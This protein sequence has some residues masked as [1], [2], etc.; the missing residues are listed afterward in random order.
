MTISIP[1]W[2]QWV[3]YIAGAD[4]WP[5]GD[6]D[7]LYDLGKIWEAG[8]QDVLDLVDDLA[9]ARTAAMSALEGE[10]AK[11][12]DQQFQKIF[13]GE[14]SAEKIAAVMKSLGET[15]RSTGRDVEHTKLIIIGMLAIAAAQIIALLWSLWGSALVA[16]VVTVFRQGIMRAIVQLIEQIAA[17]LAALAAKNTLKKLVVGKVAFKAAAGAAGKG[18]AGTVGKYAAGGA[19]LGGGMEFGIQAYQNGFG[20]RD[21]YDLKEIGL[22]AGTGLVGGAVMG[23]AGAPLRNALGKGVGGLATKLGATP[24]TA[25]NVGTRMVGGYSAAALGNTAGALSP[26]AAAS[27]GVP[28][29]WMPEGASQLHLSAASIFGGA[30]M[31]VMDVGP[32]V[33]GADGS[34]ASTPDGAGTGSSS[35]HAA[36][37]QVTALSDGASHSAK[38]FDAKIDVSGNG[39]T[40]SHTA[41]DVTNQP[42]A[43]LSN[44]GVQQ[45]APPSGHAPPATQQ[46]GATPTAPSQAAPASP[47]S[48][49]SSTVP[50]PQQHSAGI[51]QHPSASG[52]ET[53]IQAPARQPG[54]PA[55]RAMDGAVTPEGPR[56]GERATGSETPGERVVAKGD[57]DPA[58]TEQRIQAREQGDGVSTGRRDSDVVA[59]DAVVVRNRD[60][61]NTSEAVR[62][63]ESTIHPDSEAKATISPDET[64]VPRGGDPARA[65]DP[66]QPLGS[67]HPVDHTPTG[68]LEAAASASKGADIATSQL[69]QHRTE[70]SNGDVNEVRAHAEEVRRTW[71]EMDETTQQHIVEQATEPGTR[72]GLG[73]IDGLPA[74]VRDAV[75]RHSLVEDMVVLYPAHG[76]MI[77]EWAR[78]VDEY[79]GDPGNFRPPRM[80]DFE[81]RYGKSFPDTTAPTGRLAALADVFRSKFDRNVERTWEQAYRV[82]EE[83]RTRQLYAY[84][85]H[86][87]GGDGRLLMSVG[88]LDSADS[89]MVRTPGV[90]STMRS[91]ES[92]I[93]AAENHQIRASL[94]AADLETAVLVNLGYDAPAGLRLPFEA[95][96]A[97]LASLGGDQLAHD[98]AGLHTVRD[99]GASIH[100]W[101][102]SYGSVVTAFAGADAR[103][104]PFVD[105]VQLVGSP[106][107]GPMSRAGDFG[108]G[109][110]VYVA[111]ASG[112]PITRFGSMT[113]GPGQILGKF[114]LGIDPASEA[115]GAKRFA[116]EYESAN[117]KGGLLG[118]KS[119]LNYSATEHIGVDGRPTLLR[120]DPHVQVTE[121]LDNTTH[122]LTGN[123]HLLKLESAWRAPD[124]VMSRVLQ[125]DDPAST[126]PATPATGY[127]GAHEFARRTIEGFNERH[128]ENPV[129]QLP[130]SDAGMDSFVKAWNNEFRATDLDHVLTEVS[131]GK[132]AILTVMYGAAALP[133]GHPGWRSFEIEP[134]PAHPSTP[135]VY[136][137][138]TPVGWPPRHEYPVSRMEMATFD[139]DG[140]PTHPTDHGGPPEDGGSHPVARSGDPGGG[141]PSP[142]DAVMPV[143]DRHGV[144]LE[145]LVGWNELAATVGRDHLGEH[146]TPRQLQVM[147]E[148]RMA[149]PHPDVGTPMQK[150]LDSN[151]VSPILKQIENPG[152]EYQGG[153]RYNANDTGGCM[154]TKADAAGLR[155][156]AELL[157]GLRLD[158]GKTSPFNEFTT[159]DHAYVVE[160]RLA[161][162]EVRVP[163]GRI[164]EQL[165]IDHPMVRD[166]ATGDPPHTGTGY[167][168]A[169]KGLNPEYE[170]RNGKWEPGATLYRIDADGSRHPVARL[171]DGD[172]WVSVKDPADRV[173]EG[174]PKHEGT[175]RVFRTPDEVQPDSG[176]GTHRQIG[177]ENETAAGTGPPPAIEGPAAVR[178]FGES[179]SETNA[180]ASFF[181]HADAILRGTDQMVPRA[182]GEFTVDVHGNRDAVIL[183]DGA[184]NE[185]HL[186]PREFADVIRTH[187]NWDG[188]TPIRLL[189][190]DTGAGAHPF[191]RD[192]ARELGVEVTAPDRAVWAY[193]DGRE[194]VV[195]SVDRGPGPQYELRPRIPPDGTWSRFLPDGRVEPVLSRGVHDGGASAPRSHPENLGGDD[196]AVQPHGRE[197]ADLDAPAL[198]DLPDYTPGTLSNAETRAVYAH[199]ELRMQELN[200]RWAAEGMPAEERAHRMFETRNELRQWARTLMADREAAA[201]LSAN[202]KMMTWDRLV[203]KTEAK[204]FTGDE[205]FQEIIESSTRSRPGV[206]DALGIDPHNPPPLPPHHGA[207]AEGRHPGS[208]DQTPTPRGGEDSPAETSQRRIDR[209]RELVNEFRENQGK[210]ADFDSADAV[211][212][213]PHEAQDGLPPASDREPLF[214]GSDLSPAERQALRDV[215]EGLSPDERRF[216]YSV[217]PM[218]GEHAE[219]PVAVSDHYARQ[220]A[221]D[222]RDSLISDIEMR[223]NI[224]GDPMITHH[225]LAQ[226]QFLDNLLESV[227]QHEGQPPRFL[228][229]FEHDGRSIT[230]VGNPDTA[231]RMVVFAPGTFT[232]HHSLNPSLERPGLK[233]WFGFK[234]RFEKPGYMEVS[235]RIHEQLSDEFG[236][237]SVAVVDYQNYHA[238]QSLANPVTG[239][240]NARFA[241]EG[242]A[243][244]RN[245]TDRLQHTNQVGDR[246]LWV[247]G[248]SYGTVLV[249]EAAKGGHG[250][251]ADGIINLGSPGLRVDDVSG[252][253][254]KGEHLRPGDAPVHTMTRSDDPIR[255]VDKARELHLDRLGI[256][257]GLMPHHPEFGGRVWDVDGGP[258]RDPHNAYFDRDSVALHNIADIVA[259]GEPPPR[260]P[261][262]EH[263]GEPGSSHH[264][265]G[266][267]GDD[268]IGHHDVPRDQ[269][270]RCAHDANDILTT[271]TGKHA[272][273]ATEPS[274]AGVPARD[275]FEARESTA[276]F[277]SYEQVRSELLRSGDGA[278]A[279]LVSKWAG[280]GE[281]GGHAYV[282]RNDNGTVH[283]YE[284]IGDRI[285][286]SGWPPRWG[287]PAVDKT[288]VGYFDRHGNPVETLSGHLEQL[289]AADEIGDVA[290]QR[291]LESDGPANP[292]TITDKTSG[293]SVT[294]ARSE[295]VAA[296]PQGSHPV[297]PGHSVTEIHRTVG[298]SE[299]TFI[300]TEG[301]TAQVHAVLRDVYENVDRPYTEN[302][303]TRALSRLGFHG[304]HIVG[305]RFL[306]DQGEVNLFRQSE[307]FNDPVYKKMENEWATWIKKGGHVEVTIDLD[308]PGIDPHNVV[309]KYDV[310]DKHGAQVYYDRVNFENNEH[311]SFRR[312]STREIVHRLDMAERLH[313][314]TLAPL[315]D[316]VRAGHP[317][318]VGAEWFRGKDHPEGIDPQYGNPLTKHWSYTDSPTEAAR[319]NPDVAA[320]I[321]D[322]SAPYGRDPDGN[323]YTQAA[324]E[325]RFNSEGPGGMHWMNFPGNDGAVVGS[326]VLYT[327]AQAFIDSY[328]PY[329]DRIG[330]DSGKYLGVMVDGHPASWEQRAMHV[331]S[332]KD[333]YSTFALQ[334]LP[335]GWK[336][337]ISEIAPGC[338]QP[339]GGLQ[340][341]IIDHNGVVRPVAGLLDEGVLD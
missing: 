204:G 341:R 212:P 34:A 247:A 240:P 306:L 172:T 64:P 235:R 315:P 136:D 145:Q 88:N 301:K 109:V 138:D 302:K 72:T 217:E 46:G 84:D 304:G 269:D 321:D 30:T 256:G 319:M 206:N 118:M 154:S 193:P 54:L 17:R 33:H 288:A 124:D 50:A 271:L 117:L 21:G 245:H 287:E 179:A 71:A 114:G 326:R 28:S 27:L 156:P 161:E 148:A 188:H 260:L 207:E 13:G 265:S 225:E 242:A 263:G 158:Y 184:G 15:A 94:R 181:D 176:T 134:D 112:D 16:A 113:P 87:H 182:P 233:N 132:S 323:A 1:G 327:D 152:S 262:N 192:L 116:A 68:D 91:I 331:D 273:L 200:K 259:G 137:G 85:P 26:W 81:A 75:N 52:R 160:G 337:E 5:Q 44:Q 246:Q 55:A 278:T 197:G 226:L 141:Q 332:L 334:S 167:T 155:T 35:V 49:Q 272:E 208:E 236:S 56:A 220:A 338:G 234:E 310:F 292:A 61:D 48:G 25:V 209:I 129:R 258:H 153:G 201:H 180:G 168:G 65:Q 78:A 105:T 264:D 96:T 144:T 170:V 120:D 89:I 308:S 18:L 241:H 82:P 320:L 19:A 60:V 90:T 37:D 227:K 8:A 198:L 270:G 123:P 186:S 322:P 164:A 40:G 63:S 284:Q 275:L 100:L 293:H 106:G 140:R 163:I 45:Q 98:V 175:E 283:L 108:A 202:E 127:P 211:R 213:T 66:T 243:E 248:H 224:N 219:L 185:Y 59:D 9:G 295:Q 244:L 147:F 7:A 143:L 318:D 150:V 57:V 289:R 115:F 43:D 194:P 47:Q 10:A 110:D 3:A 291:R 305:F 139:P 329:L 103:V 313:Q 249:G 266:R 282:A 51:T 38:D 203:E 229:G 286:R 279:L 31:G 12:F 92:N 274:S 199:G 104:A 216:L 62:G 70:A 238:P 317:H 174:W 24:G 165:G 125:R 93:N 102:H 231:T 254:L 67:E 36:S 73:S 261:Q 142:I 223:R 309:V 111:A 162:G 166:L 135:R 303:L 340:V 335:A 325:A 196:S 83:G 285:V 42:R 311:Q 281:V 312:L 255:I 314:G 101:G 187:T 268:V 126:H 177:G 77:R 146:F 58:L 195:S 328:G 23:A 252:L 276:N 32:G 336:I 159:T 107:A 86:A 228:L 74:W 29:S 232:S 221:H 41:V 324:Y 6:E 205:I 133:D 290:G 171:E 299:A 298:S 173:V 222:L 280:D 99:G 210:P 297:F 316:P 257:H 333:S 191:A 80:S 14:A 151:S 277:S 76:P 39:H 296:Y 215:W 339:G 69:E 11:E 2:L 251:N 130:E 97:R 307:H 253:I 79:R 189:S 300:Q 218:F 119:H 20:N 214:D 183:R 239:A 95:G 190:C 53:G 169:D 128:P 230:S 250:L 121:A 4:G 330:A 122:V 237:E 157:R 267:T 149:H 22:A 178:A 294:V 131:Q